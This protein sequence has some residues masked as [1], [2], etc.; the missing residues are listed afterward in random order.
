MPSK[1]KGK[2]RVAAVKNTV[3]EGDFENEF[4]ATFDILKLIV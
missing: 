1:K 4:P 2:K 3:F